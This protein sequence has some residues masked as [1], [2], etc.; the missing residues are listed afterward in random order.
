MKK[1]IT[2][3][4]IAMGLLSALFGCKNQDPEKA[5]SF[6]PVPA[7]RPAVVIPTDR[8]VDRFR[9][10][11]DGKNDFVVLKH[12]TCVIV[13]DGLT[14]DEAGREAIA[15]VDK[16]FTYHPDMNPAP[17]D[18]GNILVRYNHPAFNV[19]LNDIAQQHWAT[20]D[21]RHQHALA[22]HEVL[23]TP[24][25]PNKFDEFGKKA[26]WGRCYFFMDAKSPEVVRVVRRTNTGIEQDASHGAGT[27]GAVPGQ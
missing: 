7:W 15:I 2:K 18:D 24:L 1:T 9:Y 11:T 6:P 26:L 12:G 10:Y 8:I 17:M 5:E 14:D 25:G 3:G 27:A 16:I 13:P 22:T 21:A 20:I 4:M 23:I 19:V